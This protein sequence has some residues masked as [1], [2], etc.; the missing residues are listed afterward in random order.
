MVPF[1]PQR[2]TLCDFYLCSTVLT[3][4]AY[5]LQLE[6]ERSSGQSFAQASGT[7]SS[8][9]SAASPCSLSPSPSRELPSDLLLGPHPTPTCA[10]EPAAGHI[11]ESSSTNAAQLG[12]TSTTAAAASAAAS[13]M[14]SLDDVASALE[15]LG[16]ARDTALPL[17]MHHMNSQASAQP[18]LQVGI[19]EPPFRTSCYASPRVFLKCTG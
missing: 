6:S 13:H 3:L 11:A 15:A 2:H 17:L 4:T 10:T 12:T 1:C 8:C 5:V 14:V 19:N 18:R 7:C 16:L 9:S